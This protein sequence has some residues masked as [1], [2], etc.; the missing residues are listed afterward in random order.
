MKYVE[1]RKLIQADFQDYADRSNF[2][3]F[4]S[5]Y[6]MNGYENEK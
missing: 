3:A 4:I 2:C 1:F 6:N 5:L